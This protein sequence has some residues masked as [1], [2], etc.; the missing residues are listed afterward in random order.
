[1]WVRSHPRATAV[2]TIACATALA[3]LGYTLSPL[4]LAPAMIAL[5]FVALRT[6]QKTAYACT[7]AAI[8][9]LVCTALIASLTGIWP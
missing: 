2:V 7:V 3:A 9:I 4:L 1:M 5:F 8:A 6:S